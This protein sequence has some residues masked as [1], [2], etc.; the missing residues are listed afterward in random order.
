V[1]GAFAFGDD[2]LPGLAKLVE[3]CGEVLQVAG[4]FM[5][6][7]GSRA[8]WSGDLRRMLLEEVAD[9]EAAIVFFTR[10]NLDDQE[11]R[12]MSRRVSAKVA[13]FEGWHADMGADPPPDLR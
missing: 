9:V 13:K 1:S 11:R 6:T 8:H 3:E 7:H 10:H 4:K 12:D 5:M 2:L